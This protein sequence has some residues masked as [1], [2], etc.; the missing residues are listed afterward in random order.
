MW[1]IAER[2]NIIPRNSMLCAKESPESFCSD[3]ARTSKE[4][5][6]H[7]TTRTCVGFDIRIEEMK[8]DEKREYPV[9]KFAKDLAPSHS[10]QPR[11]SPPIRR[12][13]LNHVVM[14][15]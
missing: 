7:K 10:G 11:D 8:L 2:L 9:L 6:D 15:M 3:F 1:T 12:N 13:G 14:T 5:L 4:V